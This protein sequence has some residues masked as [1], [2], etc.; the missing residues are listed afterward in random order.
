MSVPVI[1]CDGVVVRYRPYL[2]LK[3]TLKGTVARMRHKA[4]DEVIALDGVTFS[5]E[6]GE[7]FGVIGANGA[8]KSTLLRVLART[9]P[10]DEGSVVMNGRVSTLLALGV[11]FNTEL[12]GRRNVFLGGLAAGMTRSEIE[13]NFDSI[14]DFAEVR[15]AID[16]P[17]K[18]FSSGMFARLA[19][20]LGI[21]QH[22]DV[23]LLDEVLAVGDEAFQRKSQ[24]AM[25]DLLDGAGTVV[26]VSHALANVR[27]FCDRVLWLDAGKIRQIGPADEVVEAYVQHVQASAPINKASRLEKPWSAHKRSLVV[28]R[29]LAG[30]HIDDVAEEIDVPPERI[31]RWVTAFQ[32]AGRLALKTVDAPKSAG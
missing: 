1:V 20:S 25:R 10:P 28:M 26:L 16:R 27:R 14:V 5:V 15:H 22:P 17:L 31:E 9:L 3:P 2:D 13:A 21:H 8:G 6:R 30:E 32:N 12:S 7:A 24:E 19:F 11:G 29:V 4:V 23:I 18:T